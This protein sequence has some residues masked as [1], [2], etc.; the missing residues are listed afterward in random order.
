MRVD[1]VLATVLLLAAG[2]ASVTADGPP[3]KRMADGRTWTTANVAVEV[4]PS[5]CYDDAAANCRTYGRLYTWTS[6]KQACAAIGPGWRLPTNDEWREL[7]SRYGG[8]FSESPEA[9]KAA[10]AALMT[11]GTSGFDAVLGGGREPGGG[12]ARGGAH[13][14]YWT[15]TES[16]ARTAWLY[17][18]GRGMQALNRHEDVDKARGVSVRCVHD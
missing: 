6:A 2:A 12:Y 16:G 8:L 4:T 7:A 1:G 9:G 15:A 14:F 17:N 18:F 3:S 10:F 5:W 11:G 13:G